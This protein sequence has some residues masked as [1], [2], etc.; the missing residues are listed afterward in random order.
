M[1]KINEDKSIYLTRGDIANISVSATMPDGTPYTFKKGDIVRFK[2]FKRRDCGC[3]ELQ[4][5]T[6][7]TNVSEVVNVYLSGS[8]TKIG[9]LIS[10]PANYWYEVELN[11]DTEPQTIIGYDEDGEKIFRLYPEGSDKS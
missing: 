1:F 3:V 11:P 9:E 6:E 7:V 4:K 2:V 5:D 10:K 8:D